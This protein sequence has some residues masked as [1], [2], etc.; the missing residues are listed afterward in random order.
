MSVDEA[1]ATMDAAI[2]R[3][4]E[5]AFTDPAD[6]GWLLGQ[7]VG[8]VRRG[9]PNSARV[10]SPARYSARLPVDRSSSLVSPA[11]ARAHF[12]SSALATL[13]EYGA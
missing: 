12:A 13:S 4:L 11:L 3:F 5:D 1:R 9:G 10:S 6:V 7:C 8:S 2:A